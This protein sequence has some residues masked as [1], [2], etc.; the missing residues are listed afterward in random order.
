[1]KSC[2]FTRAG[3]VCQF[4][5]SSLEEA[6]DESRACKGLFALTDP[7]PNNSID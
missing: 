1:M 5:S 6:E 7:H 2:V 4:N 3:G